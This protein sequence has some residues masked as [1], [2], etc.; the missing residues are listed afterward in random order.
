MNINQMRL[1]LVYIFSESQTLSKKTKLSLINFIEQADEQQL[2]S[3]ALKGYIVKK[4]N[5]S[6]FF[7]VMIDDVFSKKK[8]LQEKIRYASKI[9]K[10]KIQR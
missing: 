7:R 10:Q 4:E 9:A 3:L 6:E 8:K 2:K 1:G 5:M